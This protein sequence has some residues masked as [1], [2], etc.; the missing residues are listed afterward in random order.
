MISKA[1][2]PLSPQQRQAPR[3]VL[4]QTNILQ[5]VGGLLSTCMER[6]SLHCGLHKSWAG[7]ANPS[8]SYELCMMLLLIYLIIPNTEKK[9]VFLCI[10]HPL[11]TISASDDCP[12]RAAVKLKTWKKTL[13]YQSHLYYKLQIK[14]VTVQRFPH[15]EDK[16]CV[17]IFKMINTTR[18]V[19]AT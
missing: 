19:T 16:Q 17:I 3:E 4:L 8:A 7:I 13:T 1:S 11:C 18:K 14:L 12:P 6:S 2:T 9:W 10:W 5:R 15:G